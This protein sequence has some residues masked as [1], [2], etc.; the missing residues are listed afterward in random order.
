MSLAE[1]IA[2]RGH[3]PLDILADIDPF[4]YGE[5]RQS[6]HLLRLRRRL[7]PVVQ[8]TETMYATVL[9]TVSLS[10][11]LQGVLTPVEISTVGDSEHGDSV[12][13]D[14]IEIHFVYST[15]QATLGPGLGTCLS[16]AIGNP[17][18]RVEAVV[19]VLVA[20]GGADY[21]ETGF[22][23]IGFISITCLAM[24]RHLRN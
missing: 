18:L 22:T 20:V 4:L 21:V 6:D 5:G 17:Q 7:L 11:I 19:G 2:L 10:A 14:T 16:D 9:T 3:R 13:G 1:N 24:L 12:P 15:A 8:T 23:G